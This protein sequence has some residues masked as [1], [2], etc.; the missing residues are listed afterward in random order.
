MT[1]PKPNLLPLSENLRVLLEALAARQN[2]DWA[3]QHLWS[4]ASGLGLADASGI[5]PFGRLVLDVDQHHGL[6]LSS[7][8]L[9]H[10][11]IAGGGTYRGSNGRCACG[12]RWQ[13]NETPTKGGHKRI[14]DEHR[15]HVAQVLQQVLLKEAGRLSTAGQVT[16]AAGLLK[17]VEES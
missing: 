15:D 12:E 14:K 6:N 17:H 1:H 8:V 13:N 10:S 4:R 9:G 11:P 2:F 5:S 16:A 3:S 7:R